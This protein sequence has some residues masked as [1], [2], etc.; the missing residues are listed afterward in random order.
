MPKVRAKE[1][2]PMMLKLD[3]IFTLMDELKIS[4]QHTYDGI[5]VIDSERNET[6]HLRDNDDGRGIED[7][8][9]WLEYKLV[10]DE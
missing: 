8:P 10:R 5:I 2:H 4:F 6:W 7:L 1:N 9:C 3:K